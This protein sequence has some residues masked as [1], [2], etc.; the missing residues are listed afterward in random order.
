MSETTRTAQ[1]PYGVPPPTFRLPD[2]AH[3]GA[4]HLQV[5]DLQRSLAYYEQVLGLR[6]TQRHRLFCGSRRPWRRTPLGN[7]AHE[8]WCHPS[9]TRCLRSLSLCDPVTGAQRPW[10]LCRTPGSSRCSSCY[11]RS[12]G[13]R[14][15]V[16]VG[17][18]WIGNRGVRRPTTRYAG[19]TA[20]VNLR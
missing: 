5:S 14:G 16:P 19:N 12:P 6:C 9:P 17:S 7:A 20:T 2:A 4:V 15:T 10:P 13:E 3:P 8:S 18:R 1:L 11:G